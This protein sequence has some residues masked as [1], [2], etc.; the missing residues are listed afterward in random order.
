MAKI[1][2]KKWFFGVG[3]KIVQKKGRGKLQG[4]KE[5]GRGSFIAS[6]GP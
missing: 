3:F 5:Q 1:D 4:E 2:E 6:R